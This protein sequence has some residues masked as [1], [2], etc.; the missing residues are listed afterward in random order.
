MFLKIQ[1]KIQ[2][3]IFYENVKTAKIKESLT[4]IIA[5]PTNN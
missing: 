5:I 4:K 3:L 2:D 1:R